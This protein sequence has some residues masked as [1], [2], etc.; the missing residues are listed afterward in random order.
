MALTPRYA[1]WK[2]RY[3]KGPR[4]EYFPNIMTLSGE[5]YQSLTDRTHPEAVRI[6]ER[7]RITFGTTVRSEDGAPYPLYHQSGTAKARVVTSRKL[8]A[9]PPAGA[10]PPAIWQRFGKAIQREMVKVNRRIAA[11]RRAFDRIT[12]NE[13]ANQRMTFDRSDGVN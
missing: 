13:R 8:I 6:A 11:Q 5:T 1:K 4:G 10:A 12:I 9:P 7:T 2:T 3:Y